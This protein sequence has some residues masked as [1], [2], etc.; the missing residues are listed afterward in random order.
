VYFLITT[1]HNQQTRWDRIKTHLADL[2]KNDQVFPVLAPD[3][4][5]FEHTD[6]NPKQYKQQSLTLAYYQICQTAMFLELDDYVVLE[7][8]VKI[9]HPDQVF[10]ALV[11]M[12]EDFDL[13]YLTRTTHNQESAET[14]YHDQ[15]FDRVHANY[16]ETPITAWS[17]HFAQKFVEWI[18]NKLQNGL[19]LGHI[20]HELLQMNDTGK[21][22]FFAVRDMIAVG[23]SNSDQSEM[24]KEGSITFDVTGC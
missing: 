17:Q 6:L 5:M 13:C 20:D 22:S 24:S 19:W 4:K 15:N 12:P 9:V 21:Y 7:D 1:I 16:W 10:D 18:Q 3:W 11:Q 8:D 23:L 14:T 2:I